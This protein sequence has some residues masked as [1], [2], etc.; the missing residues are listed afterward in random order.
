M[1]DVLRDLFQGRESPV[2]S[3]IRGEKNMRAILC[4]F[5]FH[6]SQ[7]WEV[8]QQGGI[9]EFGDLVGSY[10]CYT[11]E[12]QFCKIPMKKRLEW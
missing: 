12:C 3:V 4:F 8:F 1:E 2:A 11:G 9:R 7:N 6:K 5:G 10:K